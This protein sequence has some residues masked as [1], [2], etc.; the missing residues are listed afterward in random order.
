M[1]EVL[2]P[3]I[4]QLEE[5]VVVEDSLFNSLYRYFSTLEV[6]GY[7]GQKD[8]DK[9]LVLSFLYHLF[10][11]DTVDFITEEDYQLID[12]ALYCLY[13]ST[14]LIPYPEFIGYDNGTKV[15]TSQSIISSLPNGNCSII[16]GDNTL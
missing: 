9:L 5:D 12:K 4:Y 10:D 14:C 15:K 8:V 11:P 7:K 3:Q 1:S 16:L 2:K 6:T 13:G